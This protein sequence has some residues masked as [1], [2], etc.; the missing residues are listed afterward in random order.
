MNNA[1]NVTR[2]PRLLLGAAALLFAGIIYSWSVIKAPFGADGFGWSNSMLGLNYTITMCM[3]CLGG[4]FSGLIGKKISAKIR[5]AASA[6]LIFAGMFIT[7]RLDGSSPA[8]LFVGYGFMMG[9]GVGIVYNIV[10][11]LTNAWFPDKK[12]IASGVLMMS[13]G[14]SSLLLGKLA[15]YM[16]NSEIGWSK[17]YLILGAAIAAVIFVVGLLIR[18]PREEEIAPFLA[19][20]Q[21][22]AVKKAS[23]PVEEKDYTA[24]EML[25][26][27]SF[28]KL[29]IF[30]VLFSAVGGIALS[31]GKD[32]FASVGVESALAV[33]IASFLALFNGFGRLSSGAIFDA[34]G[35]RRTQFISSGVVILA[36]TATAIGIAAAQPVLTIIGVCLCAF[37]YGFSPTVSAA[38]A[39]AFYGRKNFALNFSLLN[40]VLIPSAFYA[41]IAG[42]IVDATDG[43][44]IVFIILAVFSVVGLVDNLLIKRP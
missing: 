3:F 42:K 29:F 44:L 7:S 25:K 22:K 9:L 34:V 8:L 12:G 1:K 35:I 4:L 18:G 43:F 32:V 38:L 31:F 10:I 16:F 6:V 13:F 30:F 11:A 5:M 39:G 17:T 26:R 23:A 40:L 33:N 21:A 24:V 27:A 2:L 19:A 20:V 14:F 41:T 28:W 36:S 15:N 37:S